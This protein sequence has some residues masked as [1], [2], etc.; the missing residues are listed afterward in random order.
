MMVQVRNKIQ[1][2]ARKALSIVALNHT[3]ATT[4][5]IQP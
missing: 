4:R 3:P 2:S 5:S 1:I